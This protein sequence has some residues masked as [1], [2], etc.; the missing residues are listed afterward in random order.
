MM[1][2]A[3]NDFTINRPSYGRHF[4][5]WRAACPEPWQAYTQ[6]D[7]VAG[8]GD[9][10][11]PRASF[12]H[13]LR[14][15]YIFL[16]HFSRAW[17]LAIVKA[18]DLEEMKVASATVH[19]LINDEMQLH[20]RICAAEGISEEEL[21]NTREAPQ[22]IAYTRYV[23]EAGYSGDFLDLLAALAPCVMGYGEIGA[24]LAVSEPAADYGEWINT[25]AS[26]EYQTLCRDVGKLID[27][28][29]TA[30]LGTNAEATP[31]WQALCDRFRTA[32]ELEVAFWQ[33]GLN[34]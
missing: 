4:D 15:D 8:L 33:M 1:N 16:I 14:Q 22:N 30:R 9:G 26:D 11:L 3:T 17:A 10:S 13:Y 21:Y 18:G 34:G 20:V 32:T 5:Q 12:L 19:A 28:A 6:H 31:R 2:K 23:L 25:Y 29:I 27:N 24:Q 7:F